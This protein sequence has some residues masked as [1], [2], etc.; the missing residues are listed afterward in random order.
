[1][2]GVR[3]AANSAFRLA[4]LRDLFLTEPMGL[5]VFLH[6]FSPY[7]MTRCAFHRLHL[8]DQALLWASGPLCAEAFPSQTRF[9]V[10][11]GT[12]HQVHLRDA[13]EN[14]PHPAI[15]ATG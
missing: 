6:C 8:R 5:Q 12:G 14:L 2:G 3:R 1:M 13:S 11:L 7:H 4:V 9:R 15:S 10:T